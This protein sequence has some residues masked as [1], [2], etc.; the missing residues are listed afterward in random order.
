MR[1]AVKAR[2]TKGDA[3]T[4]HDAVYETDISCFHVHSIL[5]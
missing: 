3:L 4:V 1:S 2:V 5:P